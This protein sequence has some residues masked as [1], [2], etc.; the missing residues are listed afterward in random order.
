MMIEESNLIFEF[1]EENIGESEHETDVVKL[2]GYGGGF[3]YI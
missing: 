3:G 2:Q 1:P